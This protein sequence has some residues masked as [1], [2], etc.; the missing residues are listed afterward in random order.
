MTIFEKVKSSVTPKDVARQYGVQVT[1]NH[2][3]CCPFHNDKNP[4]LKLNDTYFYCFGCGASGDVID[5]TSALLD[6]TPVSA[7]QK[8]ADDFGIDSTAKAATTPKYPQIKKFR[9]NERYCFKV[10]CEYLHVLEEW[11]TKYAPKSPDAVIDDRFTE[12]CQMLDYIEYLV[13]I[14]TVGELDVR[15]TAVKELLA[16]D[17]IQ[18]LESRILRIREEEEKHERN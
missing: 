11:K 14:L 10:L 18:D 17:K 4:S 2:M 12:A 1:H 16:D 7:A 15:V 3:I 5:F 13:D 6:L 9:E 8:L